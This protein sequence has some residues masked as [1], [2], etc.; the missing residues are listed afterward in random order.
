MIFFIY[1]NNSFAEESCEY[2]WDFKRCISE[3]QNWNNR[4]IVDFVCINWNE[5][6]F[7]IMSQIVLD[8]EFKKIDKDVEKF[9]KDLEKDKDYYFGKNAEKNF[10]DAIDLIE[11]IFDDED[12][13]FAK[14]Y[15]ELCSIWI[16]EKT[17][18]CFPDWISITNASINIWKPSWDWNTCKS[19]YKTKINI[20]KK[21]AYN[22]LKLNKLSVRKDN[23]KIYQKENRWN[24]E[25]LIDLININVRY[26]ERIWKKWPSKTKYPHH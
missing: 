6:D 25:N 9:L 1:L 11:K 13:E 15:S 22:V 26:M 4:S 5:S 7:N 20:F 14:K 24:Y 18:S 21:V 8:K 16:L 2:I 19:L 23:K 3:R 17:L 12:W 10:I